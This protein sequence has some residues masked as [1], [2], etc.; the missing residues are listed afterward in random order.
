MNYE[1][2]HALV[3]A[4]KDEAFARNLLVIRCAGTYN[5]NLARITVGAWLE[6]QRCQLSWDIKEA[7]IPAW[8]LKS[9]GEAVQSLTLR[10]LRSL[11]GEAE[12]LPGV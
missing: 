6:G 5:S 2:P 8:E 3:P 7:P 10:V 12:R 4:R 11:Y 9:M 1:D